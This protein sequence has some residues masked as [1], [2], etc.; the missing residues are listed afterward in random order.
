MHRKSWID[1]NR[2]SIGR[3]GIPHKEHPDLFFGLRENVGKA[4]RPASEGLVK[5]TVLKRE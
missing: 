2:Q 1:S 3:I 5:K 4:A